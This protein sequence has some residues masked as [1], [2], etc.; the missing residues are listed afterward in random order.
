Y[1]PFGALPMRGTGPYV[2][3]LATHEIVTLPSASTLAVLRR[4]TAG[5]KPAEKQL[6]VFADPVFGTQD[7]RLKKQTTPPQKKTEESVPSPSLS[8]TDER[9]LKLLVAGQNPSEPK[10]QIPRLPFTRQEAQALETLVPP[11]Q[12]F[13]ALNFSASKKAAIGGEIGRY[14]IVHFATHGYLDSERP[15][16]SALILS[17]VD[18]QGQPQD[19]FLR[20]RDIYNLNLQAD[21][22]VLSACQTGLGKVVKGE[23][24]VGFTRG[25]MY[26]GS[27]RVVVSL[28]N[29]NDEATAE[30]M[31]SF[32]T[33]MLKRKLRPAAALREAQLSLWRT[34]KWSQPFF[35]GAFQIQGE[36]W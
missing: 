10:L 2:P 19:G 13:S 15:E 12:R 24:V 33:N 26:A 17:L 7:E 32:Y 23:G 34:R 16:L 35:W 25:F 30:L 11:E 6:A 31:A 20:A 1:I 3:L 22:V 28:W 14:Q 21:L 5:R 27:P 36:W 18:E 9:A 29:V 4:E 8:P